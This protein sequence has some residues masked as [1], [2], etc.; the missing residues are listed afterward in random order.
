M[1]TSVRNER[2]LH[3]AERTDPTTRSWIPPRTFFTQVGFARSGNFSPRPRPPAPPFR[4]GKRRAKRAKKPPSRP[5]FRT[6][7]RAAPRPRGNTGGSALAA[8]QTRPSGGPEGGPGNQAPRPS[9][10]IRNHGNR[11]PRHAEN[12]AAS[13]RRDPPENANTGGLPPVLTGTQD[14]AGPSP[15][16]AGTLPA[17]MRRMPTAEHMTAPGPSND[18]L[19]GS[20]INY[21]D[22]G[23]GLN[24]IAGIIIRASP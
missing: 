13:L 8:G 15:D 23:R 2:S 6:A 17:R 4:T 12:T 24:A 3:R 1:L 20:I 5:A 7:R 9:E 11:Q 18:L 16:A 19:G 22:R 21:A 10:S 14:Q